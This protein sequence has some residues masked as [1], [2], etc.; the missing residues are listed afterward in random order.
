MS[1]RAGRK[2]FDV[3]GEAIVMCNTAQ[4]A[5]R[6]KTILTT[7]VEP[8]TSVLSGPRLARL[9]LELLVLKLVRTTEDLRR[10]LAQ[11]TLLMHQVR[12]LH[13]LFPRFVSPRSP[14]HYPLESTAPG[15]ERPG[16]ARV[17]LRRLGSLR[18]PPLPRLSTRRG[19]QRYR[20]ND[21]HSGPAVDSNR[22]CAVFC[23][24]RRDHSP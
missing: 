21:N 16:S 19:T 14:A 5:S 13:T 15:S 23:G 17:L 24:N 1:G 18:C 20:T 7:P 8:I 6:V 10:T 3:Q 11:D 22:A 2:G 12:W 9:I 4:E